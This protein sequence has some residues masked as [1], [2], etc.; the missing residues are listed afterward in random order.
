MECLIIAADLE[1]LKNISIIA[2]LSGL[3]VGDP[4]LLALKA[5]QDK[6]SQ[7]SVAFSTLRCLIQVW[8][9]GGALI[10][11][12]NFFRPHPDLIKSPPRPLPPPPRLFIFHFKE[13]SL[14]LPQ[15]YV[16][17]KKC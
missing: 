14:T 8:G 5:D 7:W 10:N 11:F 6:S 16:E 2:V 3:V 12:S 9:A 13:A 15:C 17:N 4:A 1:P